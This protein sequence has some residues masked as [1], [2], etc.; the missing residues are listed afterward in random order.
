MIEQKRRWITKHRVT[1]T[2]ENLEEFLNV[3]GPE[4]LSFDKL[5]HIK[6]KM[7]MFF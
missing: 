1:N 5:Q 7:E 4:Y 6:M 3:K 2:N